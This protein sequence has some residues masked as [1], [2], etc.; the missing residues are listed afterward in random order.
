MARQMVDVYAEFARNAAA[1]PVIA[2]APLLLRLCP[3]LPDWHSLPRLRTSCQATII[4][5]PR[6]RFCRMLT[7]LT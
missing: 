3:R 2:G 6:T 4:G 7:T 1:M 5:F